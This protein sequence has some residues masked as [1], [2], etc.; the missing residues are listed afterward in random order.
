M[1]ATKPEVLISKLTDQLGTPF[2]LQNLCVRGLPLQW[3]IAQC[4]YTDTEVKIQSAKLMQ[5][6]WTQIA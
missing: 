2:Q 5:V 1:A 4:R 6:T 3:H